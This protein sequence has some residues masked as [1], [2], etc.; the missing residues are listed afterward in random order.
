MIEKVFVSCG[1]RPPEERAAAGAVSRVLREEFHLE[2]Y[3]GFR[4][5]SLGD[6]MLKV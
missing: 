2:P 5:R 4:V 6:I 1:Q 3:V